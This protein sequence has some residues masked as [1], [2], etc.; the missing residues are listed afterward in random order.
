MRWKSVRVV[1]PLSILSVVLCTSVSL[2]GIDFDEGTTALYRLHTRDG[3]EYY[4]EYAVLQKDGDNIW[5]QAVTRHLPEGA[6]DII[7]Q[8]LIDNPEELTP[9]KMLVKPPGQDAVWI[10]T[11]GMGGADATLTPLSEEKAQ[12]LWDAGGTQKVVTDAG[13]FDCVYINRDETQTW[14]SNAVGPLAIVKV[15]STNGTTME[16]VSYGRQSVEDLI[17]KKPAQ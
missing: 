9:V 14:I 3:T 17:P 11:D 12:A 2:A 8:V 5:I 4:V 13:T 1:L 10:K 15:V 16:L 6:P 7:F